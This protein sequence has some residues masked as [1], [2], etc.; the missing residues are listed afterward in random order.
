MIESMIQFILAGLTSGAIYALVGLGFSIIYN[1]SH[2]INFAQGEFIVIGGM[3]TVALLAAGVPLPLAIVL[4]TLVTMLV[5]MALAKFA[6]QPAKDADVVALIIITIGASIFLRGVVQLV[7]GKDI[8]SLP[9]FSGETPLNLMGATLMPQSLWVMGIS[10]AL[11]VV[12]AWFFNATLAGKAMLATA[13]NALAARLMGVDTKWVLLSAFALSALLGA[14]GGIVVTPITFVSYES[15][16]M[17]GLKG[18]SAAVLGGLGN[19]VGAVAG[20]LILGIVEALSA[21]YLSSAYKDAIAF[22]IILVVLVFRPNGL[23]GKKGIDRV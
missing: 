22:I 9:A 17:L 13:Y 16:I 11:I 7:F 21:G 2:V 3:S 1:A 6:I 12:I 4:A 8:H 5:G 18:F 14:V 23:F 10:S 19:G 15:G 20:G